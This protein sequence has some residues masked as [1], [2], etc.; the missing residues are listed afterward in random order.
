MER[1]FLVVLLIVLVRIPAYAQEDPSTEVNIDHG[2][3]GASVLK[4]TG[5]HGETA[6]LSGL[7][8]G[9]I[10]QFEESHSI[11]LGLGAYTL[12]TDVP[13]VVA[14]P[15]GQQLPPLELNYSGFEVEYIYQPDDILHLTLP[16]MVGTG[17]VQFEQ[18]L[19]T[20][21]LA[22]VSD[23]YFIFE[24]GIALELKV[25]NWL[26]LS[27]GVSYRWTKDIEIRGTSERRLNAVNGVVTLKLGKF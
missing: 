4:I 12:K 25:F 16:V 24:P 6:L 10:I 7:R 23:S 13:A 27:T 2:G 1:A 20:G 21:N 15:N 8:G 19:L 14:V 11:S 26:R 22:K 18:K 17:S 9:W 5:I 3:F